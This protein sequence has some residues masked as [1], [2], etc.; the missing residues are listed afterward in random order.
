[1][2]D[3][4][5]L[6]TSIPMIISDPILFNGVEIQLYIIHFIYIIIYIYRGF[7]KGDPQGIMVVSQY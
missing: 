2:V 1:M 3:P 7:L 4:I 5:A 6:L